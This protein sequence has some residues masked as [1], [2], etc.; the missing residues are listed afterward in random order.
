MEKEQI[1]KFNRLIPDF[2][3]WGDSNE[4]NTWELDINKIGRTIDG[5]DR[6]DEPL[7]LLDCTESEG[8][9]Y[10]CVNTDNINE[11]SCYP[12]AEMTDYKI[13]EIRR[14]VESWLVKKDMGDLF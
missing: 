2:K 13:Y 14:I 6:S 10:L 8:D 7:V 3:R 5:F 11:F 9:W 4:P 1:N 12:I